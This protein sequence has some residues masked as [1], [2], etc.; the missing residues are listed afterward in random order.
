MCAR[1]RDD[2]RHELV[3]HTM[4]YLLSHVESPASQGAA[5]RP[6]TMDSTTST[7]GAAQSETTASVDA[8]AS[9]GAP[10]AGAV[11]AAA[12]LASV[13]KVQSSG[14]VATTP[15]CGAS[16]GTQDVRQDALL[17]AW[18]PVHKSGPTSK[19]V[20]E[21]AVAFAG[22][23]ARRCGLPA[24]QAAALAMTMVAIRELMSSATTDLPGLY[25][26]TTSCGNGRTRWT[27]AYGRSRREAAARTM[28]G[29]ATVRGA[30]DR[31][32]DA[33]PWSEVLASS[34]GA[35]TDRASLE[36]VLASAV[37]T[38]VR[39]AIADLSARA[40]ALAPRLCYEGAEQARL[41]VPPCGG[42][43]MRELYHVV[44]ASPQKRTQQATLAHAGRRLLYTIDYFTDTDVFAGVLAG[45]RSEAVEALARALPAIP[46]AELECGVRTHPLLMAEHS[47]TYHPYHGE[48]GEFD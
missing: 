46:R 38:P 27:L 26:H 47:Y 37:P 33:V 1:P 5:V 13:A 28:I 34:K 48:C 4:V 42:F 40:S 30:L 9:V 36:S 19:D 20:D 11:S 23:C 17:A 32:I 21:A 39:A 41:S 22:E 2:W 15:G 44:C 31:L 43:S 29:P 12:A 24:P 25:S 6:D 8:P 35:T 3:S 10:C 16:A 45:S 18:S 14:E 7:V